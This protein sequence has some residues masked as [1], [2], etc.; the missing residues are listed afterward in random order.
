MTNRQSLE[1]LGIDVHRIRGNSGKVKCPKC[2]HLRKKKNEPCL[3]VNI[4]KGAYNCHNPDCD[5]RGI[6][7]EKS[8]KKAEKVY[9]T[10][11]YFNRTPL[12][13]DVVH[14]WFSRGI[15]QG[16]LLKMNINFG[17][18]WM[19]QI[20]NAAYSQAID[21]GYTEQDARSFGHKNA[22]VNTVQFPYFRDGKLINIKYRDNWKNFKMCKG[23][24]LIM[25][26]VDSLKGVKKCAIVEGEPDAL[27]FVEAGFDA[28][29]SV[30]NGATM[31]EKQNLDY[32][33]SCIDLFND[34]DIVVVATDND[35][36]GINLRDELAR[37]I[38][39]DKCYKVDFGD[40]K[41]A[42]EY[43]IKYGPERLM[44]LL[45]PS[46]LTSFPL[47]GIISP[48]D[49]Y[50]EVDAILQKGLERGDLTG[51]EPIDEL[52]SWVKGHLT[53]VTG[54]P[55]SGKSPLVM[56]IMLCL[57]IRHGWKWGVF[58]PEHY[59]LAV[60]IV[61]MIEIIVGK[62]SS[63]RKINKN[64]SDLAKEFI[65]NHF[66][67]IY[68]EDEQ[69]DLDEILDKARSLVV[70]HGICGLLIDPWN[71]IEHNQPMGMTE[72][73]FIS[74]QLDKVISFD[75][76]HGVHTIIV[77]HP[78]KVSKIDNKV[79]SE[80]KV[81]NL[82]DIAGSAN[83]FN[84]PDNG[85]SFHRNFTRRE[86]ELHVQKVKYKHLGKQ[87]LARFHY[88]YNNGRFNPVNTPMD[89]SN[90]LLPKEIQSNMFVVYAQ[91]Q[92]EEITAEEGEKPAF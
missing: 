57:S 25:F 36:P 55:N 48:E 12:P 80:Y 44:E 85:L 29:V 1:D 26:N 60:F 17:P 64:E 34:I 73:N 56:M 7:G 46:M 81:V 22:V 40:V 20:Y 52:V 38:G 35:K 90:W 84:K 69:F 4:E 83:W 45:D 23:C 49:L 63:T 8:E 61:E 9:D 39:Y 41:D 79:D 21:H 16:T 71:K 3:S 5:F 62:M 88:N 75:R 32:L 43:L 10:P 30:P 51:L 87:G 2:S 59:P 24:E 91:H 58:S 6:V 78:T 14:Y 89:N 68:P 70:R 42:N 13:D 11:K 53:V 47:A 28:V 19:P 66:W 72:T 65:K 18:E 27:S 31:G 76:K 15:S 54:I 67:M 37:R 33:D 74:K 86:N 50:D 92:T 77:A 82:Y